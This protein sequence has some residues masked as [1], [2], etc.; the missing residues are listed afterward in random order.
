ME[1]VVSFIHVGT[2]VIQVPCA[3]QMTSGTTP[4]AVDL[5]DSQTFDQRSQ[6]QG[7]DMGQD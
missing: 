4:A 7:M 6:H 3:L 5:Q 2:A 1:S